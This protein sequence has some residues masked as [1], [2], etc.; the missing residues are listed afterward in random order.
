MSR[1]PRR[2]VS[3][4]LAALFTLLCGAVPTSAQTPPG[5]AAP[6]TGEELFARLRER[7]N[8]TEVTE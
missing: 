4:R 6:L 2:L 1:L 7:T 3:L 5:P 8:A